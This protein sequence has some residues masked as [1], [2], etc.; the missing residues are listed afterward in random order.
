[1]FLPGVVIDERARWMS[2]EVE[3]AIARRAEVDER[4]LHE[5]AR[6]P[7]RRGGREGLR[8]RDA[9]RRRRARGRRLRGPGR[10][11]RGPGRR[12]GGR[13]VDGPD[14]GRS[15]LSRLHRRRG[16]P[17][18]DVEQRCG[19][20]DARRD[21]AP[22]AHDDR[23]RERHHGGH[24][25]EPDRAAPGALAPWRA[26]RPQDG[27]THLD[28]ALEADARMARQ[29]AH[30]QLVD[31]RRDLPRRGALAEALGAALDLRVEQRDEARLD[32]RQ[33][34]REHL[35]EDA[36]ERVEIRAPVDAPRRG[37]LGRHVLGRPHDR[38]R[39]PGRP[40]PRA[41]R[42]RDAVALAAVVGQ[43]LREPEIEQLQAGFGD[44]GRGL[45]AARARQEQVLGLDVPVHEALG[46]R[47]L[48]RAQHLDRHGERVPPVDRGPAG[49]H[50]V[51]RLAL[52]QVH[53]AEQA[54]IRGHAEVVDLHEVLVGEARED[55]RLAAEAVRDRVGRGVLGG[56]DLER[57]AAPEVDVLRLV[58]G[59]AR[60]GA[61]LAQQPVARAGQHALVA[62]L[63]G[64]HRLGAGAHRRD[65][66]GA[67]RLRGGDEGR[68][69]AARAPR[70]A[71]EEPLHQ[72]RGPRAHAAL[73][74]RQRGRRA[75]ERGEVARGGAARR[76]PGIPVE[77]RE[78][79][80]RGVERRRRPE[81]EGDRRRIV[82]VAR[83]GGHVR[84]RVALEEAA[85]RAQLPEHDPERVEVDPRVAR[86]AVRDLRRDVARLREHDARDR[87]AAP[88]LSAGGPEVDDLHV[89]GEAEHHVLGRQ[90][91]VDDAE[92]G[93]R[94]VLALVHVGERLGD[95]RRD[96]DR[97][98]P[99]E[100]VPELHRA[101]PDL[102]EAPALDVLDD[103]V[104]LPG[105]RV[106]V[107]LDDLRD[108]G[109]LELR[110]HPRLVEEAGDVARIRRVLAADD[111][112]DHGALGPLEAGRGGEEHL[113]HASPSDA[114]QEHVAA[115][116]SGNIVR[117][118]AALVGLMRGR[119]N[120][121]GH[122]RGGVRHEPNLSDVGQ[123]GPTSR[124]RTEMGRAPAAPPPG[125]T[126]S[127]QGLSRLSTGLSTP[128]RQVAA[129]GGRPE[130][131][132]DP[133]RGPGTTAF[134]WS[135]GHC[136][137][138][139][140]RLLLGRDVATRRPAPDDLADVRVGAGPAA[141]SARRDRS[142]LRRGP[143]DDRRAAGRAVVH[144]P[145]ER[146]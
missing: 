89:A 7:L 33:A 32:E 65:G 137:P 52:Q 100:A 125:H 106:D 101:R 108:T 44:G 91:A 126:V 24:G 135:P 102:A 50:G 86:I 38:D 20:G 26:E 112:H 127:T 12:A 57:H 60:A 73:A 95:H 120:R 115:E 83:D 93:A 136:S 145:D 2:P 81:R 88:V 98:R 130:Q 62:A 48:E 53:A 45:G 46:V 113:A 110:L 141:A 132:R 41:G 129:S 34:P 11:L 103:R 80:D 64:G 146:R 40:L 5:V 144:R 43:A 76:V 55:A 118:E 116:R 90:V 13:R 4:L 66:R 51:E 121:A 6:D 36:A 142:G 71:R 140:P 97:L 92:R 56:D 114:P 61:D 79:R 39:G 68:E 75:E 30:H 111:L 94:R 99:V 67:V 123:G 9:G 122:G 29:R 133:S 117:S 58:D 22:L 109:M 78:P 14:A 105:R 96:R 1:M 42:V 134:S 3:R 19:G 104:R 119:K 82:L 16:R 87:V 8:G 49:E 18:L 23:A 27:L 63:G 31:E 47:E 77:G 84:L 143:D 107:R 17:A 35:V 139:E 25:R 59:A 37:L 138:L 69:L 74:A 10:R 128:C 28:G 124:W 21:L 15:G 54:A 72:V 131:R 85:P 70:L